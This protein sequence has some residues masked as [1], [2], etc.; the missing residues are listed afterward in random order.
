MN[1]DMQ[2]K[3]PHW[4]IIL[5]L[6][7]LLTAGCRVNQ[8][9][10]G[11]IERMSMEGFDANGL[12]L[13]VMIPVKNPNN[14]PFTITKMDIDI[15]I[16]DYDL[17]TVN[18]ISKIK[19]PANS[20]E[21]HPVTFNIDLAGGILGGG[22]AMLRLYRASEYRVKLKGEIKVRSFLVWKTIPVDENLVVER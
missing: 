12:Q 11:D 9:E 19:V 6:C 16:N 2:Q 4:Q 21:S 8:V 20:D 13:K 5:V 10:I 7:L 1:I 14:F 18:K 22:L 15:N 3:K 17:G